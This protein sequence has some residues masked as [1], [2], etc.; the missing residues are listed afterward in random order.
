M[1]P[2]EVPSFG[3]MFLPERFIK[4]VWG[5]CARYHADVAKLKAVVYLMHFGPSISPGSSETMPRYFFVS[6]LGEEGTD[7]VSL[8]P[9]VPAWRSP[10]TELQVQ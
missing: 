8:V 4:V 7:N 10:G 2:M 3:F 1:H 9:W 5:S 6:K